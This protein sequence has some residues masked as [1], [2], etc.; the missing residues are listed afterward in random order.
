M[1]AVKRVDE[2][3]DLFDSAHLLATREDVRR[4][5]DVILG[6]KREAPPALLFSSAANQRFAVNRSCVFV[7]PHGEKGARVVP[8]TA[9]LPERERLFVDAA[10]E[11]TAATQDKLFALASDVM[12]CR[13][14]G[15]GKE[16]QREDMFLWLALAS[17]YC[18]MAG[19]DDIPFL[20]TAIFDLTVGASEEKRIELR[21]SFH[22]QLLEIPRRIFVPYGHADEIA[23]Y[24]YVYRLTTVKQ[25]ADDQDENHKGEHVQHPGLTDEADDLSLLMPIR[26]SDSAGGRKLVL[27]YTLTAIALIK[28]GS[29][30][31]A[32]AA[33]GASLQYRKRGA[34]ILAELLPGDSRIQTR[35]GEFVVSA[36]ATLLEE[37][38]V[39]L[40]PMNAAEFWSDEDD[41]TKKKD[42]QEDERTLPR[43]LSQFNVF[44]TEEYGRAQGKDLEL[45]LAASTKQ[46]Y[47][48]VYFT[49]IHYAL[50]T[51]NSTKGL[52]RVRNQLTRLPKAMATLVTMPKNAQTLPTMGDYA[53]LAEGDRIDDSPVDMGKGERTQ[54]V[55]RMV[56]AATPNG[57]LLDDNKT[58]LKWDED[59]WAYFIENQL[60]WL[61]R[62]KAL[63]DKAGGTD[64]EQ[65][66]TFVAWRSWLDSYNAT[67][68]G[69]PRPVQKTSPAVQAAPVKKIKKQKEAE[70]KKAAEKEKKQVAQEEEEKKKAAAE[71][72]KQ[73]LAEEA[74]KEKKAAEAKKQQQERLAQEEA[75]KKKKAEAERKKQQQEEE[76][77][78][79]AATKAKREQEEE[80]KRRKK[81]ELEKRRQK[82]ETEAAAKK[83]SEEQERK[84]RQRQQE[85]ERARALEEAQRKQS[86]ADE[87]K[88]AE[89][90]RLEAEAREKAAEAEQLKQ[91]ERLKEAE[92]AKAKSKK[93]TAP[94]S[95]AWWDKA[96]SFAAVALAEDLG[97]HA[98][99]KGVLEY[100][101]LRVSY[102][103]NAFST[104]VTGLDGRTILRH[105]L[106]SHTFVSRL[107]HEERLATLLLTE[108]ALLREPLDLVHDDEEAFALLL[109]IIPEE[110]SRLW[111]AVDSG[112]EKNRLL[113]QLVDEYKF[114]ADADFPRQDVTRPLASRFQLV[115]AIVHFLVRKPKWRTRLN[116]THYYYRLDS[117][118]LRDEKQSA[119]V[120]A[121][122]LVDSGDRKAAEARFGTTLIDYRLS[123]DSN[124]RRALFERTLAR[125]SAFPSVAVQTIAQTMR[126]MADSSKRPRLYSIASTNLV[127]FYVEPDAPFWR[128][129]LFG[130]IGFLDP[131]VVTRDALRGE[132]KAGHADDATAP[133]S[134]DALLN[135][136]K[137][138]QRLTFAVPLELD[139]KANIASS[140]AAEALAQMVALLALA[141]F[142]VDRHWPLVIDPWTVIFHATN[143]AISLLDLKEPKMWT[144]LFKGVTK[145]A[146]EKNQLPA[147][148][149]SWRQKDVWLFEELAE[150][151][152]DKR[153][154]ARADSTLVFAQNVEFNTRQKE[155]SPYEPEAPSVF[156]ENW[157][158]GHLLNT[159]LIASLDS[160][161]PLALTGNVLTE[162]GSSSDTPQTLSVETKRQVLQEMAYVLSMPSLLLQGRDWHAL[163]H[164]QAR[165]EFG[166]NLA[167]RTQELAFA[168]RVSEWLEDAMKRV[169]SEQLLKNWADAKSQPD[170]YLA[171]IL[172]MRRLLDVDE[173]RLWQPPMPIFPGGKWE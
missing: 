171:P 65:D 119:L 102:L 76:A 173:K 52:K 2:K 156:I 151:R 110:I 74:E 109:G 13:Y 81:E 68:P 104:M 59:D 153:P 6:E 30:A 134:I 168:G 106:S 118:P 56:E 86:E 117:V 150:V 38:S 45:I 34:E 7:P 140:T 96:A 8:L 4:V 63:L 129:E 55:L 78:A 92:A 72:E 14:V 108:H 42:V 49:T 11:P 47:S 107:G 137:H 66:P 141:C 128:K 83:P 167:Q 58:R 50:D 136:L 20:G 100:E 60:N 32:Q 149:W 98:K 75:E 12:A 135:V 105:P 164:L 166:D 139:P 103:W 40:L 70:V 146:R 130:K 113:S 159:S 28:K 142:N 138:E 143:T 88:Q 35:Q 84:R 120:F 80:E 87:A 123:F 73:R 99:I 91:A 22:E 51:V 165:P 85:Q 26:L 122:P 1:A 67:R 25:L 115:Q 18:R 10:F 172:V 133:R 53:S 93:A 147:D 57:A 64:I 163:A 124:W 89:T 121:A 23:E 145:R 144:D 161:Q 37:A 114:V 157:L 155:G 152:S 19:Q 71:A 132:K 111:E 162:K 36:Q 116:V 21:R 43:I 154:G 33:L 46:E 15:S 41:E 112:T 101:Q 27:I 61:R 3:T 9:P 169:N 125:L 5:Y 17:K 97:A 69:T 126:D 82:A 62:L 77:A 39:E 158:F 29:L 31:E 44:K 170:Y 54:A 24:H 16:K 148:D 95:D 131:L 94:T 79:A 48:R 90:R 127:D 160:P